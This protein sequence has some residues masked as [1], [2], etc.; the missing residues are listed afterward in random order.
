MA[1]DAASDGGDRLALKWPNDVLLDGAKV[2]GILL[3]AVTLAGRHDA[4]S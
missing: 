1:L 2:A 3:E 4:T